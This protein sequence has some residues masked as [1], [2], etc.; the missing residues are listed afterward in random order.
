MV[1]PEEP[2]RKSKG[3]PK[4]SKDKTKR[5]TKGYKGNTNAK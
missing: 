2:K 1:I 4:G 5:S 3:R